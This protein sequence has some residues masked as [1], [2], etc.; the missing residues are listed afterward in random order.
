MHKKSQRTWNRKSY[1]FS[2]GVAGI[3]GPL[4]YVIAGACGG[5][6]AGPEPIS[7][8]VCAACAGAYAALGAGGMGAAAACFQLW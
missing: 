8:V 2:S 7:K 6:C 5:S 3:G 4:G 1:G